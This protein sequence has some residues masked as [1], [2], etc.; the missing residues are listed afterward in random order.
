[1]IE[2]WLWRV[3]HRIISLGN[4]M[5]VVVRDTIS[6][7]SDL[8]VSQPDL[9]NSTFSRVSLLPEWVYMV[10]MYIKL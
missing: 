9:T 1:M 2:G 10:C 7:L 3:C 4:M 8:A 6:A 5:G